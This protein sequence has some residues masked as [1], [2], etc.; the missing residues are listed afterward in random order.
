MN[1]S[2]FVSVVE[3]FSNFANDVDNAVKR[4]LAKAFALECKRFTLDE[5]VDDVALAFNL[6][7]LVDWNNM[8][9]AQLGSRASLACKPL[10]LS[11]SNDRLGNF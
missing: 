8:G 9:V 1:D 7:V 4:E 5:F 2:L 6:A 11:L 10:K 3:T